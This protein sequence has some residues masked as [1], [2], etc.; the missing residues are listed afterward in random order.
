[1]STERSIPNQFTMKW[2]VSG[3]TPN[4]KILENKTTPRD[5]PMST[6]L[7]TPNIK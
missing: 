3:Q 6:K 4:L 1:M 5:L 7:K 2:D